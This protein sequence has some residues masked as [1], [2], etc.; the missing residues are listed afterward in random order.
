M[1][2]KIILLVLL[3]LFVLIFIIS[4][5]KKRQFVKLFDAGNVIVSGLRGRGKDLAFCIVINARKRDYISN[6]NYSSHKKKYK[7]FPLDLKVWELAGNEYTDLISGEVKKY[8]YPYP[9]GLDYYISDAG[10]YFPSQYQ[11]EL[12]KRYKSAPMFQALSRQLGECNVHT[13][14]QN[15]PRL[16]DKIREQSDIFVR[17]HKCK[18]FRFKVF[19]KPLCYLTAYLYDKRESCENA[20]VPPKF[21]VGKTAKQAKYNFEIA[22][23]KIRKLS[24]F[25]RLPYAY[26][27]RR[28]KKILENNCVDYEK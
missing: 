6:I 14:V 16:W 13:N 17:M 8:V 19:R 27:S 26:D 9:D 10:I 12:V 7:C 4:S 15:M 24:F 20:V 3:G 21:G 22:H 11:A 18:V 25:A 5:V 1:V 2:L 23:G 28:F